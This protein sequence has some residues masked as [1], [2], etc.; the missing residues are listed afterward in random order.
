MSKFNVFHVCALYYTKNIKHQQMH[1]E[2]FFINY[3]TLLHVSTLLGHLQGETFHCR[4]TRLHYTVERECA[5]AVHCA[6]YGDVNSLWSRLILHISGVCLEC[7]LARGAIRQGGES[8][9]VATLCPVQLLYDTGAQLGNTWTFPP[10]NGSPGQRTFQAYPTN[11]Q[12]KPRPQRVHASI[13]GAMHG[14]S[15]FSLNCVVQ[16]S[17]MTMGSLSLKMTQWGQN[18]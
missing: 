18:M 17:V 14:H 15:T 5:V 1:K 9:C 13:S 2:F 8:W 16:P 7:A 11:V 3:N 4:Y 12:Y 10:P 6:A